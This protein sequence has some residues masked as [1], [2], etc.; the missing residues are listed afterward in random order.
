MKTACSTRKIHD[1]TTRL[2]KH[3]QTNESQTT[4]FFLGKKIN[5]IHAIKKSHV[6]SRPRKKETR[7]CYGSPQ[8]SPTQARKRLNASMKSEK[9]KGGKSLE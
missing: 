5:F 4:Q 7:I 2:T 6:T 1:M 8:R 9:R 3:K